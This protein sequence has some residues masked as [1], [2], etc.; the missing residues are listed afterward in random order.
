ALRRRSALQQRSVEE[1]VLAE[2]TAAVKEDRVEVEPQGVVRSE[3][4][5]GGNRHRLD[6]VDAEITVQGEVGS[7][8]LVLPD[9]DVSARDSDLRAEGDL[10]GIRLRPG[11]RLRGDRE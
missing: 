3:M 1:D 10:E 11:L 9:L 4:I 7:L 2:R 6:G 8:K 5:R